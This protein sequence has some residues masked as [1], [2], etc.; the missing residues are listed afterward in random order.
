MEHHPRGGA[1]LEDAS[2]QGLYA[3]GVVVR[4]HEV[5]D[6]DG[7]MVEETVEVQDPEGEASV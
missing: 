4:E 5:S 2:R 3:L 7:S 6:D 1:Q